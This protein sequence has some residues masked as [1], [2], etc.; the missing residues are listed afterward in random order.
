[1]DEVDK[2]LVAL[3]QKNARI[4]LKSLGE[5][6]FLSSPAVATRIERLE[7]EQI[8]NGYVAKVNKQK[9]G[10]TITAFINL[11]VESAKEAEVYQ[12]VQNCLNVLECNCVTGNYTMIMKVAFKDKQELESFIEKLQRFGKTH[13][14]IVFSTPVEARDIDLMKLEEEKAD[15]I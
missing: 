3:L 11:Q 4:P 8:I 5:Q 12:F 10:Y 7:K 14:Q 6:V 9:L 15:E 1:M 2:K 13:A